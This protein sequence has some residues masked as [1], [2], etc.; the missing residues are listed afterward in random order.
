MNLDQIDPIL[1]E[2]EALFLQGNF[3]AAREKLLKILEVNKEHG[4]ANEFLGYIA[5]NQ[6]EIDQAIMFLRVATKSSNSSVSAM[7][8]LGSLLLAT[9]KSSE[10]LGYFKKVLSIQPDFYE[11]RYELGI[12][13]AQQ[14]N[15]DEALFN[16]EL[17]LTSHPNSPEIFYNI[18][19]IHDE[20][21]SFEESL[22]YYEK[23]ID[24]NIDF[25]DAWINKGIALKELKRFKEAMICYDHVI[26]IQENST[27]AWLNMGNALKELGNFSEA[28]QCYSHALRINPD[29]S[30]AFSNLSNLHITI[31]QYQNAIKF[32]DQAITLNPKLADSWLNKGTAL[33]KLMRHEE[34]FK[35][36]HKAIE[37]KPASPEH[38]IALGD[39]LTELKRYE[40]ALEAYQKALKLDSDKDYLYG[41]SVYIKT[42][43]C[44]W[45]HYDQ[46]LIN[47]RD[48]LAQDKKVVAPFSLLA[49]LDDEAAHLKSAQLFAADKFPEIALLDPIPKR[50]K[51]QKIRLGYFSADFRS[52]P[53]AS[54]IAELFELHDRNQFEIIGLSLGADDADE[55][56]LRLQGAFDQ[57][58]NVHSLS[59]HAVAQLARDLKID[60]AID[61]GG[62]TQD[63]RTSIFSHQAAPIQIN[64]LG[65]PGT[66]GAPYMDFIIADPILIP[67]ENQKHYSEKII[68]L[69]HTYQANDRKRKI[70]TRFFERSDFDLPEN[71]FVFC[72]FNNNFKLT[73]YTLDS[74]CR[75]LKAVEGSVLWLYEGHEKTRSNLSKEFTKRGL[76]PERLIFAK[77]ISPEEH[78]ARYR[79]A[80]LFLDT[81]P[82]NAHTTTSDALWAGT[83]VLTHIGNSFAGRVAASLLTAIDMPE[84]IAKSTEEYE[85]KAIGLANNPAK[86]KAIKQRLQVNRDTTPLFN[87]PLFTK[88]LELAYT[89]IYQRY[90]DDMAPDHLWVGVEC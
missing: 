10:A 45:S 68:Y 86:L 82:Y 47:I 88:H 67:L 76:S 1:L 23:A 43:I 40:E 5:G 16:F 34:A 81:L 33:K 29:Y 15:F 73:P 77:R 48:K 46:Q 87:A 32:A 18:A 36:I 25:L 6:G 62:Y 31:R 14:Q 19:R 12:A 35:S 60:I 51:G 57:F 11:A 89:T 71:G 27:Q 54:L 75:I 44:D 63:C 53:V 13:L 17:A 22:I 79:L 28:L 52:H 84:L 69:P 50:L 85:T 30:E 78:L 49:L 41:L 83:P 37:I 24:Q 8:E 58:I 90:Q 42:L 3:D 59:D 65:Y 39:I 70:S 4:K 55:M 72:C 26:S 61:L 20:Q 56:R 9:E 21:K 2:S 74:W 64:Y 38:Q 7:Y 80:G 66:M